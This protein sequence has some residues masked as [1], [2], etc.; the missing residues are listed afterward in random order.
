MTSP[1][2][3]DPPNDLHVDPSG[4]IPDNFFRN[5]IDNIPGAVLRYRIKADGSDDFLYI[6]DAAAE[7]WGISKERALAAVD[8]IWSLVL[9]DDM[10]DVRQKLEDSARDLNLFDHQWRITPT[11]GGIKSL[12]GIGR[13]ERRKDG[14][15]IWDT[16]ILDVTDLKRAQENLQV[17][18]ATSRQGLWQWQP[19]GDRLL[20]L[21][22]WLAMTGYN[23]G[24][25]GSMAACYERGIVHC[26]DR[27]NVAEYLES[28][29]HGDQNEAE[30]EFRIRKKN[31]DYFWALTRARV[32][33]RD[34]HG[35][36]IYIIGSNIDISAQ[37]RVEEQLRIAASAF[38][39]HGPMIITDPQARVLQVNEA[40]TE[41]LQYTS[42]DVIGN[43]L[44]F[45]R[46]SRHDAAYYEDMAL[47]L[48]QQKRWSGEVWRRRKDGVEIP[49]WL[50]ITVVVD[51]QGNTTHHV[52][53]MLDISP[54]ILAEEEVERLAFHDALTGL[55]NRRYLISRID[56]AVAV[57]RRRGTEGA[58]LFLDLDH[59]KT[60]NDSMGHAAG[61]ELL[62]E[63]ATRL[64]KL[65]RQEDVV[66]R[67]GGDEF[68]LLI[69]D[70][71]PQDVLG[72]S[73]ANKFI[74][75]VAAR[76]ADELRRPF[77]IQGREIRITATIGISMYPQDLDDPSDYLR[78][79]DTAMYQGKTEGRNT[80][81][82]YRPDMA[83]RANAKLEM[84]QDLQLALSAGQFELYYQPQVLA[85]VDGFAAEGL[86]R[87]RHPAR[88][89]IAPLEFIPIAEECGLIRDIGAW[90]IECACKQLSAWRDVGALSKPTYLAVN[91][92]YLQ[93]R[94]GDFVEKLRAHC[95]RHSVSP[96][97]IVL[98]L[99]ERAVV[100]NFDETVAKMRRLRDL[101]F[102]ISLDDFG[103]G[104][105]SL[106]YL[107]RLPL[108]QI[109]IDQAFVADIGNDKKAEAI[110]RTIIALG[111]NLGLDIVAEGVETQTQF[112]FLREY[113]CSIFQGFLFSK[114]LPLNEF[115]IYIA[116]SSYR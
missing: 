96:D 66:S 114:A 41:V 82:F 36:A 95:Q 34:A 109:K 35:A 3:Q 94:E 52:A 74:N 70:A 54:R 107:R 18:V 27:A 100:E 65:I 46:S 8:S 38:E 90:V 45:L 49:M 17:A 30:I 15:I 50:N 76:I 69:A 43:D 111:E 23:L 20:P 25:V 44:N 57:A 19:D 31:G 78:F 91:V 26:A 24:E 72:Q 11:H 51:E 12:H 10:P 84:Q 32:A 87:W 48:A 88:G 101:G 40:F 13:P 68:V 80:F 5:I 2:D 104:Y 115:E 102:R 63:A 110:A 61:D 116:N 86:I 21:E 53:S 29:A 103:S 37:K 93:F 75:G 99:T 71:G 112:N 106:S 39:S 22:N 42:K 108:D 79:A 60:I 64:Q 77:M 56:A 85:G 55:P 98:E 92:S 33:E 73:T 67:L 97:T 1:S 89:Y 59:F 28:L 14:S 9:I 4:A 7:L 6:S 113:G 81:R 58:L 47:R 16:L 62:T 83:R 105:S